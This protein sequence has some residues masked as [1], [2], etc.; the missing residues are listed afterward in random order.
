[1]NALILHSVAANGG[2]ELLLCTLKKS[3]EKYLNVNVLAVTSNSEISY[4]YIDTEN[5]FINQTIL[6]KPNINN[7]LI[8]KK[9]AGIKYIPYKAKN[10]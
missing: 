6:K 7:N 10:K 9:L 2:D 5:K 1:M 3:L 4:P 8:Y